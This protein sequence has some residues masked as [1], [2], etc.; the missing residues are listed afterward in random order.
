MSGNEQS[1]KT[2]EVRGTI[3]DPS[4]PERLELRYKATVSRSEESEEMEKP[5]EK[6]MRK[7]K[8]SRS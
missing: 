4:L 1:E 5:V 6:I 3:N 8:E 7:I 2:G